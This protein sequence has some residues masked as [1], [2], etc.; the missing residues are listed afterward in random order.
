MHKTSFFLSKFTAKLTALLFLNTPSSTSTL[1][2]LTFLT[3]IH[4][5]WLQR[6]RTNIHLALMELHPPKQ[7]TINVDVCLYLT[8]SCLIWKKKNV[9]NTT[10][11][12]NPAW[13]GSWVYSGTHESELGGAHFTGPLFVSQ[14]T[15]IMGALSEVFH[16]A[17]GYLFSTYLSSTHIR[18]LVGARL[19]FPKNLASLGQCGNL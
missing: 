3:G 11:R 17:R 18:F 5:G 10:L 15:E 19:I 16:Q 1:L 14:L 12:D 8:F 6:E 4:S 13:A 2:S 9:L 7:L